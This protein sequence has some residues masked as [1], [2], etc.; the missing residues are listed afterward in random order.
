MEDPIAVLDIGSHSCRISIFSI[1]NHK[2][3]LIERHKIATRL[4]AGM[5]HD[6]CLTKE[7]MLET[8]AA[9]DSLYQSAKAH[10]CSTFLSCATAAVRNAKNQEEFLEMVQKAIG[11]RLRVLSGQEEAK[12]GFLS[13]ANSLDLPGQ[14]LLMDTG[15]ASAE[16]SHVENGAL[17]E[18]VSLPLGAVVMTEQ[19]LERDRILPGSL[20]SLF[21]HL[22]QTIGSLDFLKN[23]PPVPLVVLGGPNKCL[24]KLKVKTDSIHGVSLSDHEVF[25]SFVS[26]ANEDNEERKKVLNS[27]GEGDRS[28][29]IVAGMAPCVYL[30][31][32]AK[33]PKL[34]VCDQGLEYGLMYEYLKGVDCL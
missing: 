9:I 7:R 31:L 14:Y 3:T 19:F 18:H 24:G 5:S 20:F 15:G 21:A 11:L 25:S 6:N 32:H 17:K 4:S 26:L 27:I 22:H 8:V 1:Q 29:I 12:I 16:I 30:M 34:T 10:G 33:S 13:V 28:D 2:P 23:I